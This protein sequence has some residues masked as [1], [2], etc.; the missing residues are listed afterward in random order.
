[1]DQARIMFSPCLQVSPCQFDILP[2]MLVS[3]AHIKHLFSVPT[4]PNQHLTLVIQLCPA[5]SDASVCFTPH[6]DAHPHGMARCPWHIGASVCVI[7]PSDAR[8]LCILLV[9][10]MHHVCWCNCCNNTPCCDQAFLVAAM[11]YSIAPMA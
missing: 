3:Q 11:N 2:L 7:N 1:M 4:N 8:P 9:P 6:T 5:L 10:A